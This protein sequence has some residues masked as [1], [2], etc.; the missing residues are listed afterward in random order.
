L[1]SITIA[2]CAVICGADRGVAREAFG[3]ARY[4]WRPG[5]GEL[6]QGL[7]SP[8]TRGRGVARGSAGAWQRCLARWR[9]AV[10]PV[11]PGPGIASDGKT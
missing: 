8:D 2:I 5:L 7:P 1:A 6:P 10:F 11:T 3:T 9:Q 4:D